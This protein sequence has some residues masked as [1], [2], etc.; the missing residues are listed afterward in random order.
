MIMDFVGTIIV[1]GII[2]IIMQRF[3]YD[4]NINYINNYVCINTVIIINT[5]LIFID[6]S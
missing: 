5:R 1:K 3:Q 4:V 2:M 6:P